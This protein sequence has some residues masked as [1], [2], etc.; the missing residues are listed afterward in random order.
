MESVNSVQATNSDHCMI[1]A[2]FNLKAI[3]VRKQQIEIRNMS[4]Y[5]PENFQF[6][7][8][9]SLDNLFLDNSQTPET[10]VQML[11]AAIESAADICCPRIKIT[12][13]KQHSKWVDKRIREHIVKRN[14]WHK[15]YLINHDQPNWRQ[16]YAEY[17]YNQFK[18]ERNL[19]KTLLSKTKS[20]N[21]A[22]EVKILKT[23]K[24]PGEN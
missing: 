8:S 7:L 13:K 17:C 2:V 14:N 11:T 19:V 10:Q 15:L 12:V 3:A 1:S 9:N 22:N 5:S 24:M 21:Y 18:K 4:K 16:G 23:L 6:F 20:E